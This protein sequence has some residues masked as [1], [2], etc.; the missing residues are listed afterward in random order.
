MLSAAAAH[1][2]HQF[3]LLITYQVGHARVREIKLAREGGGVKQNKHTIGT[4][5]QDRS[6]K[7]IKSLMLSN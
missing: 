2:R 4:T 7:Q 3:L 5:K 1:H 6:G